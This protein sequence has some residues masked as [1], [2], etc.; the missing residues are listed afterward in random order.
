MSATLAPPNLSARCPKN[1][2]ARMKAIANEVNAGHTV[3]P[4]ATKSSDTN[5]IIAP[6]PK[7]LN[8]RPTPGTYTAQITA[9]SGERARGG[10]E[11]CGA[12]AGYKRSARGTL[13]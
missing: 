13:V 10:R 12:G 5:A 8:A 4:R 9:E 1:T 7:L 3:H 6:K 11:T 2:R